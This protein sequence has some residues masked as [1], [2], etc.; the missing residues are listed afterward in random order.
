MKKKFPIPV[1]LNQRIVFDILAMIE[2][3]FSSISEVKTT[4]GTSKSKQE[5]GTAT[6]GI[7]N[8]MSTLLK[9][10]VNA[11]R[12]T[13]NQDTGQTERKFEKIHTPASLLNKVMKFM[14]HEK[15]SIVIEGALD[16]RKI[17]NG[18]FIDITTRLSPDPVYKVMTEM[19]K[20]TG[21]L[22]GH[23]QAFGV[24]ADSEIEAQIKA[25]AELFNDGDIIYVVGELYNSIYKVILSIE[26][27]SVLRGMDLRQ[28]TGNYRVFGKVSNIISDQNKSFDFGAG[29]NFDIL[30]RLNPDVGE[31]I[32]NLPLDLSSKT[33]NRQVSG[34]L[35]QITPIAIY[36]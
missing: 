11:N 36:V 14:E 20:L 31:D 32:E 5:A 10:D 33:Q 35:I 34:P 23:G 2:D 16:I 6:F 4:D 30:K 18:D 12:Q 3:G 17:D 7:S 19:T 29:T 15:D 28:I 22:T 8:V 25:M 21:L 24:Q 27:D 9:I 1:Y 26:P 13:Q